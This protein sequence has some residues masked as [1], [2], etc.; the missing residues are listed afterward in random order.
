M[1]KVIAFV[2]VAVCFSVTTAM[3]QGGGGGQQMTPEQRT[4]MMKER[5]KALGLNDVQTDSVIAIS[6]DMRP[7]QMALREVAE[8][9]RPAKMKEIAEERDAR[10][11][12]ALPADLAKKVIEAMS[13]QRGGGRPA[14]G[15]GGGK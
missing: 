15:G 9:D 13:Q 6:N 10:L 5:Y 4:A 7:K 3:A 11:M 1:K 12:K 8:A 2:A 14:G